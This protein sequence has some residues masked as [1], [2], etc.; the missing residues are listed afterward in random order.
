MEDIKIGLNTSTKAVMSH[1]QAQRDMAVSDLE[2]YLNRPVG[3][4]EHINVTSDIIILF[5]RLEKATSMLE[6]LNK[7][8]VNNANTNANVNDSENQ[9]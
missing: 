5:E 2:I 7:M 8:I 3:I 1:F 9:L 4:G 6:M